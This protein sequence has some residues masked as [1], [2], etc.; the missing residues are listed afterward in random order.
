MGQSNIPLQC[1]ETPVAKGEAD[2]FGIC[3]YSKPLAQRLISERD[4][5]HT[6]FDVQ[7]Q[8]L[9]K[10]YIRKGMLLWTLTS[11]F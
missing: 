2:E 3:D 1:G 4:I 6:E 9:N 8:I 10:R 11:I 5:M 7:G